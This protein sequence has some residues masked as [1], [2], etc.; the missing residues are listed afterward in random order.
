VL[1]WRWRWVLQ[2]R[3][4]RG[5]SKPPHAAA[6]KTRGGERLRKRHRRGVRCGLGRRAEAN[7]RGQV[8]TVSTTSKPGSSCCPGMSL[9][10]VLLAGQAAS[11]REVARAQFRLWCGT[12]EIL[13]SKF[14]VMV[15]WPGRGSASSSRNC[16]RSSTV[17]GQEVGPPGS[18]EEALVMGVERSGRVVQVRCPVNQRELGGAG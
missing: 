18:S 17:A 13:A 1:H 8:E 16:E 5:G 10:G 11:G 7:H 15:G 14:L 6:F 3:P 12:W 9:A 4:A 2:D